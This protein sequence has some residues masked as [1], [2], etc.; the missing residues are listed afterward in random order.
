MTIMRSYDKCYVYLVKREYAV[1]N[2]PLKQHSLYEG[3]LMECMT[4][5]GKQEVASM[6]L[7]KFIRKL[8]DIADE[9]TVE[10]NPRIMFK[11]SDGKFSQ[12]LKLSLEVLHGEKVVVLRTF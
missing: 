10:E 2:Q 12:V 3:T 8:D 7:T 6:T 11:H 4:W 1:S 9:R 5:I